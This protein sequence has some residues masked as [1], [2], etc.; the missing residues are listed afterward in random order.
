[1]GC[2]FRDELI[3]QSVKDESSDRDQAHL[4]ER[5]GCSSDESHEWGPNQQGGCEVLTKACV[6]NGRQSSVMDDVRRE[7]RGECAF[8][9]VPMQAVPKHL[10]KDALVV[11]RQ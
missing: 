3:G 2:V 8:K 9:P 4:Q 5:K 6:A 1:M 10:L 7:L 11:A